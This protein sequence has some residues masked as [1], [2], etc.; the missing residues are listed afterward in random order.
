MK[1]I[2]Y[3]EYCNADDFPI[4]IVDLKTV[5]PRMRVDFATRNSVVESGKPLCFHCDG[6]GN[7]FVYSYKMCP[8]CKGTGEKRQ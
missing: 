7:E 2:T 6:T 1:T 4:A 8:D 5:D 3:D